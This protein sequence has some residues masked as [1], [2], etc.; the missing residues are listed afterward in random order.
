MCWPFFGS[1]SASTVHAHAADSIA[2]GCSDFL[3]QMHKKPA[4]VRFV[5]CSYVPEQQGK[6]MRAMYRVDGRYALQAEAY[7]VKAVG[8]NKL[9]RSCCQWDSP[10]HQF[11]VRNGREFSISMVSPES[12]IAVRGNWRKIPMFEISVETLTEE[13]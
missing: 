7:L 9:R 10:T 1:L 5:K 13:I 4:Y 3:A 11:R 2:Q 8:M 6:P 12:E